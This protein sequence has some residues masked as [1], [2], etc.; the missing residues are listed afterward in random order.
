LRLSRKFLLRRRPFLRRADR[1]RIGAPRDAVKILFD[2]RTFS[3]RK[4]RELL[5][6]S[7]NARHV[8]AKRRRRCK[9]SGRNNSPLRLF[10]GAKSQIAIRNYRRYAA[11]CLELAAK[12]ANEL[13]RLRLLEMAAGWRYLASALERRM[14]A[15]SS[16][17]D[18]LR[19][20]DFAKTRF[21]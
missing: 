10:S 2:D 13:D 9:S 3:R 6:I 15:A 18:A 19:P 5:F 8:A 4:Q 11:D 20:V 17:N 1:K 16:A 12:T 21:A 7:M 14:E